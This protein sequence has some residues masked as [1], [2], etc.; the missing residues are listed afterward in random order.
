M[1]LGAARYWI[2]AF[3]FMCMCGVVVKMFLR[4]AFNIKYIMVGPMAFNI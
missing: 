4:L 1:K 2:T 3:F